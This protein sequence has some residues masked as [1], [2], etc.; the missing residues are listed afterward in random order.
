MLASIF[1][2]IKDNASAWYG[3]SLLR[4]ATLDDNIEINL[5]IHQATSESNKINGLIDQA[6]ISAIS[7]GNFE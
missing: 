6:V 7:D 2:L 1:C 3:V 4:E 5:K